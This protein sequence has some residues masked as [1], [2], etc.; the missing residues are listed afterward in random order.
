MEQEQLKKINTEL[1]VY[2]NESTFISNSCRN[3]V[4]RLLGNS[5]D[6]KLPV[7]NFLKVDIS[8]LEDGSIVMRDEV[9]KQEQT[10]SF[11]EV[12]IRYQ[13]FKEKADLLLK[14]R[15][16]LTFPNND[17]NNIKNLF[18]ILI[19]LVLFIV[20]VIYAIRSFFTHD[21]INCIWLFLF[22]STWFIPKFRDRFHQAIDYIKRKL[23]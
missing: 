7:D 17:Y 23:K 20:L 22:L 9:Y 5:F 6:I 18:V 3:R 2:M 16:K 13:S 4:I 14:R 8:L 12:L 10:L 11:D 15:N 1:K 19:V 21:F